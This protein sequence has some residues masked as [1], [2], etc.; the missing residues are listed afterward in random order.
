M[1]IRAYQPSDFE[2]IVSI[3]LEGFDGIAIDQLVEKHLGLLDGRDWRYRKAKQIEEDCA[4][5]PTGVFVAEIG[6]SV[7]GYITTRID[8]D[9]GKGRIPNLAVAADS[10]GRGIG[11]Q[12]IEHA[13]EYFRREDLSFVMIET[14]ANNAVG[15]HL[16]PACGFIELGRQ[17]HY[18]IRLRDHT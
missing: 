8:R 18:A 15:Q 10:H 11:R 17:I 2:R 9:I 6:G 7:E 3:T 16:Y 13:L 5:A 12:L 1:L 4:A 14:M